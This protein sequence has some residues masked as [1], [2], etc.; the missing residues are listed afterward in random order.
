MRILYVADGRSPIA[1]NW[2]NHFIETGHE[3]HLV[4]TFACNPQPAPDSLHIIPI[5]FSGAIRSTGK[6]QAGSH[7]HRR[8]TG[9]GGIGLRSFIRHWLGP[10]TL[11]AAARNLR[12][13]IDV[14]QPDMIHAM[15]IP[16]EGMLAA[17]AGP[18]AP[19]LVSIWGNDFTLHAN[20]APGMA[21][22]TRRTLRRANALHADCRRDLSLARRWGWKEGLPEI[23]LPGNGGV[24]TDIFHP[25]ALPAEIKAHNKSQA[26]SRTLQFASSK[27][28]IIVNPRGFRAYIRND[29]FFRAI[30]FIRS[31]YPQ[32]IFLCP[33][34][35][36]E[37]RAK[38][39]IEKLQISEAVCLLPRLSPEE[40]A[41]V[42]SQADISISP[43]EHDGT[44]NT[45]LEAMACG[46]FPVAG[47]LESIRE[48]IEDGINGRLIDPGDPE[49]L[50]DAVISTMADDSLRKR[51]K[52]KNQGLIVD[53]ATYDKVMLQADAFYERIVG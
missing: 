23:V 38:A 16:F 2:I 37:P 21:M 53:R 12:Q 25:H 4:S 49:E 24:R 5:A 44:P 11:P 51:A 14:I 6:D 15:R 20:A 31:A 46:C 22:L 48:W 43:S 32:A 34:M 26:L 13:L 35:A 3:V 8:L 9:A 19:L 7:S 50:A 41:C 33:A 39:W 27:A 52:S 10:L 17:A 1:I 40:M 30:P 45:L 28:P 47:D 29:T 18:D 42:F 36:G